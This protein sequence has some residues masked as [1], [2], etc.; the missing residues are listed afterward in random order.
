MRSEE[1]LVGAQTWPQRQLFKASTL[2]YQ[3]DPSNN[4]S[5][6]QKGPLTYLATKTSTYYTYVD[7]ILDVGVDLI[8]HI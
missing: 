3:C 8:L 6:D 7:V 2:H 4:C 1:W 5:C